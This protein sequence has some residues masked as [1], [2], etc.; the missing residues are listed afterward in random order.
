MNI[1]AIDSSAKAASAAIV[2]EK[3]VLA[4]FNLNVKLTHSQTLM[5]M[6]KQVLACAEFDWED[7]DG[8]AVSK[9]PGSFTGLRI[10]VAAAKG[11]AFARSLPCVG[12]STLRALAYN[13]L[14]FEG[15]ACAVMD[16]RRGQVYNG[17][18]SLHG[19][20]LTRLCSDRAISVAELKQ[21]LSP[22]KVPVF[23]VGDGADLCYH[24]M[25]DLSFVRQAPVHSVN[26]RAASVGLAAL[27]AFI[28]GQ[29][30][31]AKELMPTYLRLPQAERE[32]LERQ[33]QEHKDN[34]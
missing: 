9:G 18:F 22:M 10:G 23:L 34:A 12:V 26:A 32:R 21:E 14:G 29:T 15:V 24:E 27:P 5:P 8:I 30:V 16:A 13:L 7:I 17:M 4:E 33:Q 28:T 1:L 6:C 20:N 19:G 2:C 31:S 3:A 25:Q 11:I